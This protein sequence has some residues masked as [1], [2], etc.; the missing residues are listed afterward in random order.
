[1]EN[2]RAGQAPNVLAAEAWSERRFVLIGANGIRMAVRGG[3]GSVTSRSKRTCQ[4]AR[5]D[6]AS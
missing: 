2:Y 5:A 1:V 6:C 3:V 4:E